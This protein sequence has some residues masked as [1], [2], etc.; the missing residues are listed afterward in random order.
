[1]EFFSVYWAWTS[2]PLRRTRRAHD[3]LAMRRWNPTATGGVSRTSSSKQD[4]ARRW[5]AGCLGNI[6]V[7]TSPHRQLG[8]AE[9][10]L[11]IVVRLAAKY[12]GRALLIR[13][14][15]LSSLLLR[16]CSQKRIT[17]IP[18]SLRREHALSSRARFRSI[19]AFQNPLFARGR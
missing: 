16:S 5:A 9:F 18:C 2:L 4:C 11:H 19:F 15:H 10:H 7:G 8:Q 12:H 13:L 6:R 14:M 3:A 17:L 1:M